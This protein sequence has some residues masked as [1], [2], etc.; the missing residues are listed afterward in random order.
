MC[1]A[2][3]FTQSFS[4]VVVEI[5]LVLSCLV[6]VP[7]AFCCPHFT[8]PLFSNAGSKALL[9]NSWLASRRR[10]LRSSRSDATPTLVPCCIW[11]ITSGKQRR[12]CF[13]SNIRITELRGYGL[14]YFQKF[15]RARRPSCVLKFC[16]SK[17]N[18]A[19]VQTMQHADR[20]NLVF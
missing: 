8:D 7:L 6:D 17:E 2:T 14:D 1:F 12:I 9:P 19:C 3:L 20:K 4:A 15:L 16:Y 18:T 10:R 13:A 11:K 5:I